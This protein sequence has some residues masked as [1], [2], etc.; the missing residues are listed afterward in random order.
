[1]DLYSELEWRELLYDVGLL[2]EGG[3]TPFADLMER[4]RHPRE[5]PLG[6]PLVG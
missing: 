2:P 1:M 3:G 4:I 5:A 6:H